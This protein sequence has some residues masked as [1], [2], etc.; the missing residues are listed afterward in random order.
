[1]TKPRKSSLGAGVFPAL[2][3]PSWRTAGSSSR[4][5]GSRKSAFPLEPSVHSAV[6]EDGGGTEDTAVLGG[7]GGHGPAQ[8]FLLQETQ[9]VAPSAKRKLPGRPDSS[10]PEAGG[11]GSGQ[12][13]SHCWSHQEWGRSLLRPPPMQVAGCPSRHG[14]DP[15]GGSTSCF[16]VAWGGASDPSLSGAH[17]LAAKDVGRVI[18]ASRSATWKVGFVSHQ[19]NPGR[20][21]IFWAWPGVIHGPRPDS[22]GGGGPP[23]MWD[24]HTDPR[25]SIGWPS[26][27]LVS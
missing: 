13:P 15:A 22:A 21:L 25:S 11:L 14:P 24:G 9:S 6:T 7:H 5:L 18:G 10:G 26:G 12:L 19:D 8:R 4:S 16:L 27:T 17:I 20:A 23:A 2:V 1:M 3:R